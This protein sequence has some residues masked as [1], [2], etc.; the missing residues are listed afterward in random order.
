MIIP[1]LFGG[2]ASST[3]KVQF[4]FGFFVNLF[5]A[6]GLTI[7]YK[8]IFTMDGAF[9]GLTLALHIM[10]FMLPFIIGAL[11][12]APAYARA[13]WFVDRNK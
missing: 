9:F 10:G 11:F 12:V 13:F 1:A 5:I 8:Y 3:K 4:Y 2:T 6:L 7:A